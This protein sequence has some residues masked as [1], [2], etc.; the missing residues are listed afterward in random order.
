MDYNNK[1]PS[2]SNSYDKSSY[3]MDS[4]Y[5]HPSYSN[6]YDKSSYYKDSNDGKYNDHK[7]KVKEY[8]C[9]T[10]HFEGF[11]VSSVEFCLDKKFDDRK[12]H[13]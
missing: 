1:Q 2:Y 10:G 3:S 7:N 13:R 9:R 5:K 12:H 6:N 11:L 8:E 4:N